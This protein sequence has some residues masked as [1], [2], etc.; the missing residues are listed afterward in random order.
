MTAFPTVLF[1]KSGG[2]A[3]ITLNRP[4]ALNAYSVRM[5]DDL[6]EVLSAV[7]WD[8]EIRVVILKGA[9]ERAF[10]AGADLKEFMTATS[11]VKARQIRVARDLWRLFLAVRQPLIAALHGFVLGSGMEMALLSDLRIASTDAVF[12]L[13]EVG[14]GIIPGA[15]GT[16]SLPRIMGL[17][18]SL[19]ML[20]T[21]RRIDA[22]EAYNSG[23]VN[24][25][26]P[27]A[28]LLPAVEQIALQIASFD[29]VAVAAAKEAMRR[30][31]DLPL[32]QGL[33]L[34]ATLAS[35]LRLP[36]RNA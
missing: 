15:G 11:A 29:P 1:E 27:R 13:P 7:T 5:R 14:L 24:R 18:R 8:D 12:G 21:N 9:G 25:V 35:R 31:Y 26:V 22:N 32:P 6:Y 33:A 10:C 17:S 23:L 16:Q 36:R 34:E 30:G 20:L 3:Y 4:E 28:E 2:L 19:D